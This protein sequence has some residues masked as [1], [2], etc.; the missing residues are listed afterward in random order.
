MCFSSH[1]AFWRMCCSG[2]EPRLDAAGAL[3]ACL[4]V[5]FSHV[6]SVGNACLKCGAL[7]GR[8]RC[9]WVLFTCVVVVAAAVV[10]LFLLVCLLCGSSLL[11]ACWVLFQLLRWWD[12]H[13][14]G[15]TE[16]RLSLEVGLVGSACF[17]FSVLAACI[18]ERYGAPSWTQQARWCLACCFA[19]GFFMGNLP[20]SAGA[21]PGRC[22]PAWCVLGCRTSC[23]NLRYWVRGSFPNARRSSLNC[24]AHFAA[25]CHYPHAQALAHT[26]FLPTPLQSIC[27][28]I[29]AL[30]SGSAPT[31]L[32]PPT[33]P[34][35]H[36]S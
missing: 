7:P 11:L 31:L 8:C 20:S 18:H 15:S 34:Q 35:T 10:V 24:K 5:C 6:V 33:P 26:H 28:A 23:H 19:V 22:R 12:A 3:A 27:Q 17:L 13:F 4:V 9:A 25:P 2:V 14:S 29:L 32:D 30:V 21:L 1:V 16:P 36:A